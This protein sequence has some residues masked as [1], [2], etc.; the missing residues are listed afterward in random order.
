MNIEFERDTLFEEVWTTPMRT[1]AQK[2]GLSDSGLRKVCIALTIPLPGAGHWAKVAAGHTI[3]VPPLPP[4]A[5]KTQFVSRPAVVDHTDVVPQRDGPVLKAALA[6]EAATENVVAVAGEMLQPHPIVRAT[7]RRVRGE[8]AGLER[9]RMESV[10]P[11]MPRDRLE[12]ALRS[13]LK[14]PSWFLYQ[15]RHVMQFGDDVLPM[16]VSIDTAERALRIWDAVIKACVARHMKVAL[17]PRGLLVTSGADEVVMRLAERVAGKGEERRAS[18]VLR[19]TFGRES[20]DRVVDEPGRPLEGQL[21]DLLCR[22]HREMA[23][24]RHSRLVDGACKAREQAAQADRERAAEIAAEAE[25]QQAAERRR[26]H[27]IEA[28][29]RARMARMV[30]LEAQLV[31]EANSWRQAEAIRSYIAHLTSTI[32]S[33]ALAGPELRDWLTWAAAVA[34]RLDPTSTRLS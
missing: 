3:P 6:F 21:N 17:T 20:R 34:A 12:P 11:R 27:E 14:G 4:T 26:Q 29:E 30:E 19:I 24:A 31:A 15:A 28:E 10:K 7:A 16:S 32:A 22:V 18:G 13:S 23:S 25:R 5:G 8:V 1:L 33:G 2:Y 9:A